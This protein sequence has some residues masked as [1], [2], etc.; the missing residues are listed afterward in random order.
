MYIQEKFHKDKKV[1][2]KR[3]VKLSDGSDISVYFSP[4]PGIVKSG[5]VPLIENAKKSIYIP[6]FYLTSRDIFKS[7]IKAKKRGINVKVIVDAHYATSQ[8]SNIKK[9]R[10]EKIKVKVENWGG[11]MHMKSLIVDDTYFIVGSTNFTKTG[12]NENDENMLIIKN[13]ELS[14]AFSEKFMMYWKS[15]PDKWLYDIPLPESKDSTYSC[16]DGIDNDHDGAFDK[17]DSDCK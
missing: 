3:D 15:I 14:K 1:I 8:H 12:F 16:N 10:D 9:L 11:K 13:P 4:N 5:I 6:M 7:L 2:F 17:N